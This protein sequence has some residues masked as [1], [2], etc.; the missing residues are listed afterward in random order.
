MEKQD[1]IRKI[2]L[3]FNLNEETINTS[4]NRFL[5]DLKELNYQDLYQSI[6]EKTRR[7][8]PSLA[9]FDELLDNYRNPPKLGVGYK[10]PS[11][12]MQQGNPE[13]FG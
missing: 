8:I 9:L 11:A 4:V 5:K 12:D 13:G 7:E 6:E 3:K 10:K 2:S 1:F